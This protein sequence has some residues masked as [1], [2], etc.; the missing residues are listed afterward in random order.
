MFSGV[1]TGMAPSSSVSSSALTVPWK[2]HQAI[3]LGHTQKVEERL[4]NREETSR[5]AARGSD[6][7]KNQKCIMD[8][9]YTCMVM[10]VLIDE[11]KRDS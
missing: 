11:K 8:V 10:S 1:T 4:E 7:L 9:L 3:L 2:P 6:G 5:R